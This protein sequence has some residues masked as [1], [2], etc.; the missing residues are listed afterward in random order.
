MN[1]AAR[2]AKALLS[3]CRE[4]QVSEA[5]F[6]QVESGLNV[7]AESLG[8]SR[9]LR[10]ALQ[11]PLTTRQEKEKVLAAL[12]MNAAYPVI[13]QNFVRL[14]VRNQRCD[15]LRAILFEFKAL[16]ATEAGQVIGIVEGADVLTSEQL[17]RLAD[18]LSAGA[19][20]KVSLVF[21][22][23]P[24]LIAGLRVSLSGVTYDG[25]VRGQLERLKR[26]FGLAA[27]RL[28]QAG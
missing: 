16:R 1:V 17:L 24:E 2:Y 27:E 15:L 11:S 22:K 10:I 6:E 23:R 8:A 19:Q 26:E 28:G 4:R 18:R 20:Q 14:L 21:N 7:F 12:I 25:S 9:A 5:E 3:I 13:V